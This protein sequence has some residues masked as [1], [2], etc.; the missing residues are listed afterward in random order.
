MIKK[1]LI[2]NMTRM[3]DLI[4]STPLIEGLHKK[5]PQAEITMIVSSDFVEFAG[6]IPQVKENIVFNLRQFNERVALNTPIQ[7][8]S[9]DI[10]KAAMINIHRAMVK[11]PEK[12][13][14]R[15][16]LQVHDELLFEVPEAELDAFGRWARS[17]MESAVRLKVPLV[18]DLKAGANWQDMERIR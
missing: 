7:G 11:F 16:V 17:E 1:I 6:R 14:S 8:T 15:P 5:H 3:G 2:L 13:K 18:V 10:I 12:W 9:A 4:Q